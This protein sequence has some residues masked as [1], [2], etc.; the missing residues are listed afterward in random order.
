M[1]TMKPLGAHLVHQAFFLNDV[2]IK[3][4][5]VKLGQYN[6]IERLH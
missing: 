6:Y 5:A 2:I 3:I 4:I 1:F